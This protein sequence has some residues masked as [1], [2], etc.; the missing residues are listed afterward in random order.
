ME[1]KVQE[2]IDAFNQ[3]SPENQRTFL[4]YARNAYNVANPSGDESAEGFKTEQT[5]IHDE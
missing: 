1:S 3:L 4:E 2:I 5:H